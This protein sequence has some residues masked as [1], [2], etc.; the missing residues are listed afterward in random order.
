MHPIVSNFSNYLHFSFIVV[1][2]ERDDTLE[3]LVFDLELN[4]WTHIPVE[5]FDDIS[6]FTKSF[7]INFNGEINFIRV[8]P[9]FT[10]SYKFKLQEQSWIENINPIIDHQFL[11]QSEQLY[12]FNL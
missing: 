7:L 2:A 12:I 1:I 3:S 9:N 8:A 5:D 10:K 6:T 4:S 11:L